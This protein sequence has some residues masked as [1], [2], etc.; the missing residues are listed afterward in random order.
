MAEKKEKSEKK[1][2]KSERISW[3][4]VN[5]DL[6]MKLGDTTQKFDITVIFP[7]FKKYNEIQKM[8]IKNGIA[9]KLGDSVARDKDHALTATEKVQVIKKTW[10]SIAVDKVWRTKGVSK[11]K[12]LEEA[13]MKAQELVKKGLLSE[14]AFKTLFPN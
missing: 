11:A 4:L 1:K 2:E 9:Q 14:E 6:V 10:Y 5:N 3:E 7:E 12:V 13:K 8:V